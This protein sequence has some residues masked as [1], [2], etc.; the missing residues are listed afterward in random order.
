MKKIDKFWK[1]LSDNQ[2]IKCTNSIT[3]VEETFPDAIIDMEETVAIN[4]EF[5]K[6]AIEKWL[7]SN[8]K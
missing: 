7:K 4:W 5:D 3:G 1:M 8:L 2:F 6:K